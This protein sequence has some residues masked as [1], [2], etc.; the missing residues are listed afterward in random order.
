LSGTR[1]AAAFPTKS[2]HDYTFWPPVAREDNV[3]GDRNPACS[4]VGM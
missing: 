1:E 4:C 2:L 3:F